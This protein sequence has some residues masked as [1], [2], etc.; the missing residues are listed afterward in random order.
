MRRIP[1]IQPGSVGSFSGCDKPPHGVTMLAVDVE[2]E[3]ASGYLTEG[4]KAPGFPLE[5]DH[6]WLF[7]RGS[8]KAF[9]A[10]RD[11]RRFRALD[12]PS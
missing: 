3:D 1:Y 11:E 10:K 4:T 6:L 12:I 2:R 9:Y 8:S 5:I 7:V